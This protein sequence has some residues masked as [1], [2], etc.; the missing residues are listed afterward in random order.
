MDGQLSEEVKEARN[1]DLLEVVNAH[2][3]RKH[4]ELVGQRVEILC[5]GP[6][7]T[8]ALR[9]SGRTRA[10]KI[11]VFE[12]GPR[13]VGRI[14]DVKVVHSSGFTLYGDVAPRRAAAAVNDGMPLPRCPRS[15]TR[16]ANT[17]PRTPNRFR[18]AA[19]PSRGA[20]LPA[21][22][23]FPFFDFSMTYHDLSLKLVGVLLGLL[24]IGSHV[25]AL[26]REN[27]VRRWLTALPRAYNFGVADPRRWTSSGPS[28]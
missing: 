26:L 19:S 14:F 13:H 24:I 11:V 7:K 28:A 8:N 5:E 21:P 9:L 23:A 27:T 4:A 20:R 2:A 12:G 25:F 1:H 10:N 17:W 16:S 22:G 18:T 3:R 6:S 15:R